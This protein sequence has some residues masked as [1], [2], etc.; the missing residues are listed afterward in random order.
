MRSTGHGA[1][2]PIGRKIR[3][4]TTISREKSKAGLRGEGMVRLWLQ[5]TTTAVV[6]VMGGF[7][8]PAREKDR[9]ERKKEMLCRKRA[10]GVSPQRHVL[11]SGGGLPADGIS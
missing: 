8:L 7:P 6:L 3:Q 1:A 10:V 11:L 4:R 9:R 5:Q 2:V